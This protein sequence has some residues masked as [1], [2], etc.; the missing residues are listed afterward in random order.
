MEDESNDY[1]SISFPGA[2]RRKC[3]DFE[4]KTKRSVSRIFGNNYTELTRLNHLTAAAFSPS[5]IGHVCYLSFEG[6][7]QFRLPYAMDCIN[8]TTTF[9]CTTFT[10]R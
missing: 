2:V 3:S 10:M 7:R 1:K 8:S 9:L 5:K 6:R 4:M